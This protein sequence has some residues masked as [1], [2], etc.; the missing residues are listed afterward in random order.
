MANR[1]GDEFGRAK[2]GDRRLNQTLIKLATRFAEQP[3][4][5]IPIACWDWAETL[6]S[7]HKVCDILVKLL[8]P[9]VSISS[10][11]D[12]RAAEKLY[13]CLPAWRERPLDE[14]PYLFLAARYEQVLEAGQLVDCAVLRK[15]DR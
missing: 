12:S 13:A 9:K 1:V 6:V 7:T 8:G 3:T 15:L 11:Q 4:A 5:S 10:T 14:T 2:L